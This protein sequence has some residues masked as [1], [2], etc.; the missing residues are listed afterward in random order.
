MIA[1][2]FGAVG[3]LSI[4]RLAIRRI[5]IESAEF[6]SLEIQDLIVTRLRAAEVTVTDSLTLPGSCVDHEISS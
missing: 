2:A 6:K 5:L 1:T 4:R 3:A